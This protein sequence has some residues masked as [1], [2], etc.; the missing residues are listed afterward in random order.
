MASV[1][2]IYGKAGA[3]PLARADGLARVR[4]PQRH[5]TDAFFAAV[6]RRRR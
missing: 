3:A 4:A 5:G 2:E 1:V 6:L